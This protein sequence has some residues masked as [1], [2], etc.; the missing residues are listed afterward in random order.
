MATERASTID[1][2]RANGRTGRLSRTTTERAAS[3]AC[4]AANVNLEGRESR[5]CFGI[6]SCTIVDDQFFD[7][8]R[9]TEVDREPRVSSFGNVRVTEVAEAVIDAIRPRI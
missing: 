8:V 1:G 6:S 2:E 4:E 9:R 7:R 3:V 5:Q